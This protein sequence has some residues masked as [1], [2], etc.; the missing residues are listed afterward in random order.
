VIVVLRR[1]RREKEEI[2]EKGEKSR[3]N[4]SGSSGRRR[5]Y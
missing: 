1:G 4:W 5:R 2:R 3:R